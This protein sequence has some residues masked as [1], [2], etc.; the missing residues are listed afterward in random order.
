MKTPF[1]KKTFILKWNPAISS[2]NLDDWDFW[3]AKKEFLVPNWSVHEHEKVDIGDECYQS[4]CKIWHDGSLFY[5]N[6][7]EVEIICK[8]L[9]FG[10]TSKYEKDYIAVTI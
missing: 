8:V 10:M 5:V 6:I 4:L 7:N 2:V 3:V 1:E 9:E